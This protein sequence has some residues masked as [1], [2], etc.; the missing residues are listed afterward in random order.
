MPAPGSALP[1]RG[2]A[3]P[4]A[5]RVVCSALLEEIALTRRQRTSRFEN[6]LYENSLKHLLAVGT[7]FQ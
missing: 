7:N 6:D 4:R 2:H 1:V 3:S 5:G